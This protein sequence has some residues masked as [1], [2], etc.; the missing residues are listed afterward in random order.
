MFLSEFIM[1]VISTLLVVLENHFYRLDL[2]WN[3]LQAIKNWGSIVKCFSLLCFWIGFNLLNSPIHW[4]YLVSFSRYF[5]LSCIQSMMIKV[6]QR[7]RFYYCKHRFIRLLQNLMCRLLGLI[8]I[9]FNF[10][11]WVNLS[12]AIILVYMSW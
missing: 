8:F 2:D 5:L 11:I 3:L 1:P 4:L 12:T 9:V 7:V 6:R 10:R